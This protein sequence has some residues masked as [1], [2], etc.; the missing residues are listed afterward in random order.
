MR[1]FRRGSCGL[2]AGTLS[3]L[4]LMACLSRTAPR[5]A[6]PGISLEPGTCYAVPVADGRAE[7]RLPSRGDGGGRALLIISSLASHEA[8][9]EV[10][11]S[12][13]R[14]QTAA[15]ASL[16][17]IEPLRQTSLNLGSR[18]L[19]MRTAAGT[20]EKWRTP[21]AG[22]DPPRLPDRGNSTKSGPKLRSGVECRPSQA[23]GD[24]DCE[25]EPQRRTFD[26][27]ITSGPLDDPD[28]F[29]RVAARE[30]GRGRRARIF[31]DEQL[32]ENQLAPGLVDALL[33]TLDDRVLPAVEG[34][35]GQIRDV[36]GDGTL[37]VLLTPWLSQLQGGR[38]SLDG[39]VR[40]SDYRVDLPRPL[41]NQADM[42]YLN[43]DL[44]PGDHLETLLTHELTHAVA[45]GLRTPGGLTT[46][47]LPLEE[48]WLNEGLAHVMESLANPRS[49]SN[50]DYRVARFL[51]NPR[52][53][54]LVVTDYHAANRWRDHGCRGATFLFLHWCVTQFGDTLP[55]RLIHGPATGRRNLELATGHTFAELYRRWTIALA[56]SRLRADG[57]MLGPT[58]VSATRKQS[59]TCS[60]DSL[61]LQGRFGRSP[62]SGPR[63]ENVD[64]DGSEARITLRGT[65]TA[66]LELS[67]GGPAN[68][69]SGDIREVQVTAD[70]AA[71][72]QITLIPL[73]V[74][75]PS[76]HR[77]PEPYHGPTPQPSTVAVAPQ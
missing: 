32:S 33:K 18:Q 20:G 76:S 57:R 56:A 45:A 7:F 25:T 52:V 50:L 63:I 16:R 21:T 43:S 73:P 62:L 14:G 55:H 58:D 36:D 68:D 61:C 8:A 37:A 70:P 13:S 34:R 9:T 39:F 26:I 30:V 12:G 53:S 27:H 66:F 74:D 6:T 54:P 48:D 46:G 42:L 23:G 10:T 15:S 77:R 60:V 17:R 69:G 59:G 75:A 19:P 29:V 2:L 47:G 5:D 24:S 65:T 44:G 67:A 3:L 71:R 64:L 22:F 40:T 49:W 51:E 35:L 11:V 38:T 4:S 1:F 41:S 31:L 72:L 28:Q